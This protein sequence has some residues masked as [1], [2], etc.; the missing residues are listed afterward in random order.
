MSNALSSTSAELFAAYEKHLADLKSN[1]IKDPDDANVTAG[2]A[3]LRTLG[4]QMLDLKIQIDAINLKALKTTL[5]AGALGTLAQQI[6]QHAQETN[7]AVGQY[8]DSLDQ[9]KGLANQMNK[10]IELAKSVAARLV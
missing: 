7:Q 3:Q 8:T 10:G 1:I 5:D 4:T 9:A 6:R 2:M